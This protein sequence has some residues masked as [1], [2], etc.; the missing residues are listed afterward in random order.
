MITKTQSYSTTDGAIFHTLELA[1]VHELGRILGHGSSVQSECEAM[2]LLLVKHK[3]E[4]ID[5]LST[6]PRSIPKARAINGGSKKRKP[7]TVVAPDIGEQREMGA[8]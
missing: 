6:G 5:I 2:G 1:Q 7:K 8:V 3:E 4:V